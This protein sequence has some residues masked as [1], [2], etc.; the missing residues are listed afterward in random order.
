MSIDSERDFNNQNF[1]DTIKE[2]SERT[3][4]L[5]AN[6]A[7]NNI[8]PLQAALTI[9]SSQTWGSGDSGIKTLTG[10]PEDTKYVWGRIVATVP[11]SHTLGIRPASTGTNHVHLPTGTHNE[12][13]S[14]ATNGSNEIYLSITGASNVGGISLFITCYAR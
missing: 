3:R 9:W 14:F 5:E 4:I 8:K 10:L 12:N 1:F 11:S 13:V 2:L 6:P 7:G